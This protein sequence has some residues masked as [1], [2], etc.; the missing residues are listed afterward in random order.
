MSATSIYLATFE[1]SKM[2]VHT[3]ARYMVRTDSRLCLRVAEE[4][5]SW[6]SSEAPLAALQRIYP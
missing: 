6:P 1:R 5:G 2:D 3:F 4:V